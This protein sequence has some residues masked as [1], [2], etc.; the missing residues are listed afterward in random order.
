MRQFR[1]L[2]SVL[3]LAAAATAALAGAEAMEVIEVYDPEMEGVVAPSLIQAS[4]TSPEFPPAALAARMSGSV[5]LAAV[6]NDDGSVGEVVVLD[7]AHPRLGFEEAAIEAMSGWRFHPALY[8]GAPVHS[9]TIVRLDFDDLGTR[10][11]P[12]P[13][14]AASFLRDSPFGVIAG[15]TLIDGLSGRGAGNSPAASGGGGKDSLQKYGKA[16]R[17]G[18]YNR[19]DLIPPREML[20]A[21]PSPVDN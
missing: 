5:L 15:G 21:L 1:T 11:R 4:R 3:M 6:V 8:D 2:A 13:V 10:A 17:S 14:L 12:H 9:Y 20:A 7:S 18:L 16:P 19:R